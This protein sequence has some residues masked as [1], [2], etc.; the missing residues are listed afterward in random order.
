MMSPM[1][2]E[3]KFVIA[4]LPLRQRFKIIRWRLVQ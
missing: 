3:M 1:H 2:S 4:F